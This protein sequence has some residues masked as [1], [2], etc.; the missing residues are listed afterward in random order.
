[1]NRL[2]LVF[3]CLLLIGT[4]SPTLANLTGIQIL[5]EQYRGSGTATEGFSYSW[6]GEEFFAIVTAGGP[7]GLGYATAD[8]WASW[9][10]QP[11]GSGTLHADFE[12]VGQYGDGCFTTLYD[13][14]AGVEM[15]N[16]FGGAD[17]FSHDWWVDDTHVYAMSLYAFTSAYGGEGNVTFGRVVFDVPVL[18]PVPVF[19]AVPAPASVTLVLFGLSS[20]TAVKRWNGLLKKTK[21]HTLCY[22]ESKG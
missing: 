14:T 4:A 21:I 1:M 11:I 13:S 17:F 3:V 10:F 20:L 16:V 18:Q 5:S 15:L 6:S 9:S 2:F 12:L 8:S 22:P 7:E 19:Q